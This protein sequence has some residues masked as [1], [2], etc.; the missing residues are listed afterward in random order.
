MNSPGDITSAI[1]A[2]RS[3]ILGELAL[4]F[5]RK[6]F[7]HLLEQEY[8]DCPKCGKQL[9]TRSKHKRQLESSIGGF[10]L[11]RPY[12]YCTACE[13]GFYPLDEALGLASSAKQYDVQ[14][15]E[16]WL[17]SEMPF[18]TASEA[19]RC[20]TANSLSTHHLH[21]CANCI[22]KDLECWMCAPTR[23]KWMPELPGWR[24][25]SIAVLS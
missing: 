21:D 10:V 25:A 13:H 19:Y 7:G 23:R 20:C 1:M 24:P 17:G 11:E 3:E 18:E 5:V 8:C 4:G 9:H 12:F 22:G 14:A 6:R 16:A 15:L 2:N